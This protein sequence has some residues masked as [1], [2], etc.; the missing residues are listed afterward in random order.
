MSSAWK[1]SAKIAFNSGLSFMYFLWDSINSSY[2][3]KK[4]RK[5]HMFPVC[6]DEPGLLFCQEIWIPFQGLA[7][8]VGIL[9]YLEAPLTY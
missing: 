9:E 6:D 1:K 2:G 4:G 5:I 3:E 8:R 7:P